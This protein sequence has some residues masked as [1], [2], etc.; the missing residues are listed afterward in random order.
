MYNDV[1]CILISKDQI[2]EKVAEIGKRISADFEGKNPIIVGVLKGSFIFMADLVR[3]I[4]CHCSVDF[5]CVSSYGSGTRTSGQIRIIKDLDTNIDGRHVIVIEDILDSGVTLSNLLRML[6]DRNPASVS[7]CALL[8]K[9]ARRK[10]HVDIDYNGFEVP[11]EFIIGYG[12]D[13]DERYRNMPDIC[14]LKP[15]VYG[16]N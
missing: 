4:S 15:E 5:M 1:K 6:K 12:L 8:D 16:E 10:A 13:Y 9:P 14:I 7:L 2:A 11:D 3:H